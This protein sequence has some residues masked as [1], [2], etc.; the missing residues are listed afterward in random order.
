MMAK[1]SRQATVHNVVGSVLALTAAAGAVVFAAFGP[2]VTP[3]PTAQPVEVASEPGDI[4]LVC[5]AALQLPSGVGAD[6]EFD[7][8]PESA[9]TWLQAQ[10]IDGPGVIQLP[11]EEGAHRW[12]QLW[13][14][15]G[16]PSATLKWEAES[17]DAG[18]RAAGA[19]VVA[20][21]P[22]GDLTGIAAGACEPASFDKWLAGLTTVPGTSTR[23]VMHNPGD[24][25]LTVTV[26]AWGASGPLVT[27]DSIRIQIAPGT[28][29]FTL[30]E[31][32]F[33]DQRR[34]A[35]RLTS[36]GGPFH[37]VIQHNELDGLEPAGMDY[38]TASGTP[39]S[40][41]AIAGVR[42]D[43]TNLTTQAPSRIQFLNPGDEDRTTEFSL[44]GTNGPV[45]VPGWDTT[46][47]LP[48][49]TVTEVSLAGLP[50]GDYALVG[51]ADGDVL[52][53]AVIVRGA[54]TGTPDN[55][56]DIAWTAGL[57][58]HDVG[59]RSVIAVPEG[60]DG[61]I[62]IS[63]ASE[64]GAAEGTLTLWGRDGAVLR[65]TTFMAPH[66]TVFAI[67]LSELTADLDEP[68]SAVSVTSGTLLQWALGIENL[69]WADTGDHALA[70]L[71]PVALT[72]RGQVVTV[73]QIP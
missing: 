14:P 59:V 54:A 63:P 37:A 25:S 17:S 27:D 49:G 21:V 24:S 15:S 20:A 8:A 7:P 33:P 40:T 32:L 36:S 68:V 38:V 34:L 2:D 56:Q 71:A 45:D 29:Q 52:V 60:V 6:P 62:S 1:R 65:E 66:S 53:T 10:L 48:A 23:L 16:T 41:Y 5:P 64:I 61:Y 31:G 50:A 70:L 57:P 47:S 35:L 26:T 58:A 30:V 13:D 9:H 19:S 69:T 11:G 55:P 46:V 39:T 42:L 43:E 18:L 12:S 73:Q 72:E 44:L 51:E 4:T 22:A 28:S 3:L 67:Q